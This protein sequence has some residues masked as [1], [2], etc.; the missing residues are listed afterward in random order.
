MDD[1]KASTDRPAIELEKIEITPE[2]VRA[3]VEILAE[4][5]GVIS[6]YGAEELAEVVFRAM[7]DSAPYALVPCGNAEDSRS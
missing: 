7:M 6:E 5:W 2:M 3:G 1:G 4:K